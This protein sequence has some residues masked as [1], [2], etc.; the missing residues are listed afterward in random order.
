MTYTMKCKKSDSKY[1]PV[2]YPFK[3]YTP[4]DDTA[5][6][7]EDPNIDAKKLW[8]DIMRWSYLT[9]FIFYV[10][11]ILSKLFKTNDDLLDD[12]NWWTDNVFGSFRTKL[13]LIIII[14]IT[15]IN[16]VVCGFLMA[17]KPITRTSMWTW[18]PDLILTFISV[19][20]IMALT[21]S[22]TNVNTFYTLNGVQKTMAVF[23]ALLAYNSFVDLVLWNRLTP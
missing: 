7:I 15:F 6:D 14:L 5:Q 13:I 23:V 18:L 11:Y 3:N 1:T 12:Y 20:L 21:I 22:A 16:S 2:Y 19:L 9:I 8:I 17:I 10:M 4:E